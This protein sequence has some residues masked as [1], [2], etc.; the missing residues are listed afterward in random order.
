MWNIYIC[1]DIRQWMWWC[2]YECN[3][4]KWHVCWIKKEKT[5]STYLVTL[6]KPNHI[7]M[8]P[9]E[10]NDYTARQRSDHFSLQK[11]T[12]NAKHRLWD[13]KSLIFIWD[14]NIVQIMT[15]A[16]FRNLFYKVSEMEIMHWLWLIC[17]ADMLC[18]SFQTENDIC[19]SPSRA[20]M[21]PLQR[22]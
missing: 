21:T 8:P 9:R 7:C 18:P 22:S 20:I 12:S 4:D 15:F 3:C 16:I 11:Q 1:I 13:H 14:G 6:L 19:S 10:N 5:R 17:H 2:F